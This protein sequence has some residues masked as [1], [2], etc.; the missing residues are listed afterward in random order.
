MDPIGLG[1]ESFDAIGAYRTTE[2][3]RP[4]DA[5]SEMEGRVFEG[6]AELGALLREDPKVTECLARRY[7]RHVTGRLEGPG[8]ARA[9]AALVERF[10]GAGRRL[11]AL[12]LETV[13]SAG[14]REASAAVEESP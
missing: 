3:D 1:L 2:A 14:F 9:I 8:Q 4:V 13:L 10:E 12:M 5:R 7:F 11:S 6:P